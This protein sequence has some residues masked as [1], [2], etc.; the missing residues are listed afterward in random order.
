MKGG[1]RGKEKERGGGRGKERE[2]E[3]EGRERVYAL[4]HNGVT[5]ICSF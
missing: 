2:K 3:R 1:G 4:T 5:I